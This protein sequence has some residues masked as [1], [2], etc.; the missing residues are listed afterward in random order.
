MI[1]FSDLKVG[2]SFE[3]RR[4]PSTEYVLGEVT[5]VESWHRRLSEITATW[6]AVLKSADGTHFFAEDRFA[7]A[8]KR[9]RIREF[10]KPANFGSHHLWVNPHT[11]LID[12]LDR[13]VI[14]NRFQLMQREDPI[15]RE[16]LVAKKVWLT[17]AQMTVAR[18]MWKAGLELV[19]IRAER[20]K[21]DTETSVRVTIDPEDY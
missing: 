10:A 5:R 6:R 20:T 3:V 19:K 8:L 14:L 15:F 13:G 16:Y 4:S 11:E 12:G 18:E 9:G 21:R 2:A 1:K 7:D 17:P